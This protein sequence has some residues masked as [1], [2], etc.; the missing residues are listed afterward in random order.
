MAE[1]DRALSAVE[2]ELARVERELAGYEE[3]VRSRERLLA[4]R[5]ALVG[6]ARAPRRVSQDEVAD[7]L[8]ANPDSRPAAI[9]EALGVPVT[10]VS[11]H[12]YRGRESRFIRGERGWRLR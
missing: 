4:A 9:A 12:L 1:P 8:A 7:Y 2:R 3:L 10:N 11:A 5:A 6:G